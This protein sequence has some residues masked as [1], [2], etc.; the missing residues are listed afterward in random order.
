MGISKLSEDQLW[1][2]FL[3]KIKAIEKASEPQQPEGRLAGQ[4]QSRGNHRGRQGDQPVGSQKSQ[5]NEHQTKNDGS[6]Q[7]GQKNHDKLAEQKD[8]PLARGLDAV[9]PFFAGLKPAREEEYCRI[10]DLEIE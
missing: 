2:Q 1:P 6:G 4:N 3:R 7:K 5:P 10:G 8:Q 9:R